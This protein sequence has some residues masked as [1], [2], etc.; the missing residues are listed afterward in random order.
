[1]LFR[2]L[3]SVTS[4]VTLP[5]ESR[6]ASG[7]YGGFVAAVQSVAMVALALAFAVAS[8]TPVPAPAAERP[9]RRRR[10]GAASENRG[11]GRFA[12]RG[13]WPAGRC[14]L[15]GEARAGA[16]GQGPGG[17]GRQCRGL[18]RHRL[19]RP[20]A[21]RLVGAGGDRRRHPRA[22]RQRHV[23]GDRSQGHAGG[24]RGDR[25]AARR[26]ADRRAHRRHAGRRPIWA[27]TT[28]AT[29]R[30]SIPTLRPRTACCSILSSS[31]A[32]P[33]TPGSI[34]A[35]ERIPTPPASMPSSSASCPRSRSWSLK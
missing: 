5:A 33:P 15:P 2:S 7:S 19:R 22:R 3:F 31:T 12:R 35:M 13:L 26:A 11:P 25:A 1:M 34:S 10:C 14:R 27:P 18:R 21:A 32:S 20:R 29:S 23:A 28:A 9:V 30:R 6:P 16:Q 4:S 17:R 8:W 24:A